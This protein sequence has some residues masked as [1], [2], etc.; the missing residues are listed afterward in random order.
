MRLVIPLDERESILDIDLILKNNRLSVLDDG[1]VV[2]NYDS[3]LAF[4]NNEITAIGAGNIRG[5]PFDI[6]INPKKTVKWLP[7]LTKLKLHLF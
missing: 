2:K 7:I 6:R 4:H 3:K 5:M 1:V